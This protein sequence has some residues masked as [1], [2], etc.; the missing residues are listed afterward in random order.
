MVSDAISIAFAAPIG[1]DVSQCLSV[2]YMVSWL[3]FSTWC[4]RFE[5]ALVPAATGV[6]AIISGVVNNICA[7][8]IALDGSQRL[9]LASMASRG[10]ISTWCI[11]CIDALVADAF[12]TFLDL[13]GTVRYGRFVVQVVWQV[14][15]SPW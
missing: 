11:R 3:D 2:A 10:S 4:V 5:I 12:R 7:V 1:L 8:R 6:S 14:W 15:K 9:L 13:I